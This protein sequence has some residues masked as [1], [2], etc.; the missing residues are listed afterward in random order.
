MSSRLEQ[1]QANIAP[2]R[3]QLIQHP[4]YSGI[5][6]LQDLQIFMEHHV[7][8]VWDFM[9]LLKRLQL[10][11]TCTSLPW[12]PVGTASTRYLIN[13]IVIGEESDV[14]QFGTRK[15]HFELYLDAMQQAGAS[16]SAISSLVHA[17]RNGHSISD[18]LQANEGP[19]G[20]RQFT[21]HTMQVVQ[22]LPLS[23]VA[24]VFTF[25]R[26][27][28]IPGMFMEF[29]RELNKLHQD[30]VSIF[31]YYLER[32]IEVDGDH[33]SILATQMTAEL[34]ADN[35]QLWADATN[36]VIAA[37]QSRIKLWDSILLAINSAKS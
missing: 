5:A 26:E 16:T 12:V 31:Q 20:A 35:D 29:V 10:G 36:A 6:T 19:V 17:V 25:G 27:D 28:I 9:S 8:A 21:S 22:H 11:L 34:C 14:D 15:S 18:I 23:S 32:H 33:H 4:I 13:E 1:L 7:Y 37:M 2:Y 30:Q 3:Q 24:A